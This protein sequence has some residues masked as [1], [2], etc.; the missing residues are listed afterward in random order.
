[1]G[2]EEGVGGQEA[3][4]DG[5]EV[6]GD[7]LKRHISVKKLKKEKKKTTHEDAVKR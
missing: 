3:E 5:L 1:M 6:A 7:E 2:E 4:N